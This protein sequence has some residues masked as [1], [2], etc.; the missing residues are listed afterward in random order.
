MCSVAPIAVVRIGKMRSDMNA[1]ILPPLVTVIPGLK[2]STAT[3]N[4]VT[5]IIANKKVVGM[6]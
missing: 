5:T 1:S 3:M 6:I 4:A 2:T